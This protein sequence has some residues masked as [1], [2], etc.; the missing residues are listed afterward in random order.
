M[1]FFFFLVNPPPAV[2][3]SAHNARMH[4]DMEA[5]LGVSFMTIFPFFFFTETVT[6]RSSSFF[7]FFAVS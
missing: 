4:N 1:S 2:L 6:V 5:F 3:L 7:F